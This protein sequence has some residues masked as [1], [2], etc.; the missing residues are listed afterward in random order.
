MGS[1]KLAESLFDW[2]NKPLEI[3]A[4]NTVRQVLDSLNDH[5]LMQDEMA[6]DYV[7]PKQRYNE[8]P[9]RFRIWGENQ[10]NFYCFVNDSD[11]NKVNPPVYFETCLDLVRDCGFD[12]T[13]V[14]P[15]N[16]VLATECFT[17]FLSFMLAHHIC[18]R[19]EKGHHLA[20]D[21]NGIVFSHPL[22]KCIG[23]VNPLGREFPGG[24]T[25]FIGDGVVCIPHWG[26][27][28]IPHWGAAF[29]HDTARDEFMSLTKPTV[30]QS[31]SKQRA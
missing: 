16:I 13:H 6:Q 26:V 24:Y 30:G 31:W 3:S 15:G 5:P 11:A 17:S 29:R 12:P 4:E 19:L 10:D 1:F 18:L 22:E 20:E 8:H 7:M 27:V 21:V 2:F 9:A 28:C 23:L 14:L 25:P